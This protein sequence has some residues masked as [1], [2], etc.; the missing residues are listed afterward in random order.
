MSTT[1]DAIHRDPTILDRAIEHRRPLDI[2]KNGVVA[3]TLIP[4]Q[5]QSMLEAREI[6]SRRFAKPDWRFSVGASLDRE[7]PNSRG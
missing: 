4:R 2:I 1:L 5:T 3:A 6:M 7:E